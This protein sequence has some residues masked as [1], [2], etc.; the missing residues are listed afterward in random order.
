MYR[1]DLVMFLEVLVALAVGVFPSGARP[2]GRLWHIRAVP[3]VTTWIL[4]A[5]AS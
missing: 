3:T 1:E 2:A 4:M 5:V